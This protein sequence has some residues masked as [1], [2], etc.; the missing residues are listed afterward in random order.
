MLS[1][2]SLALGLSLLT[3]S[4]PP[5]PRAAA[6]LAA[7]SA[8]SFSLPSPIE[9]LKRLSSAEARELQRELLELAFEQDPQ[10]V[11][12]RSLDLAR[13]VRV[14]G[15]ETVQGLSSAAAAPEPPVIL[16]RM[17][18]ELGATYVKLGQFIASSPTLFPP[19][20]VQ[21][22]QKCLDATPPMPWSDVKEIVEAE[23]GRPIGQ[24]Y[25]S[26]D[27]T[28]LAAA[29]I[30]QVHAARL[31][32]GED[33]VLKVQKKGVQGSLKADL[34]LLYANARVLQLLGAAT[35]LAAQ[36]TEQFAEFLARSPE[37]DGVVTVPKVYR[38]A[39][40]SRLLTLERLYGVPLI[41]LE[42]VRKYQP[43]PE[44]AL[45]VALNTWVS[46]VLTNEWFHADVHAGNLLVLTDGRDFPAGRV[47]FIDF[48]IV[49][50][51][52]AATAEGMLDFV[53]SFPAGDMA[54]VGRALEKMGFTKELSEEQSAAF[55]KD[56]GEVIASIDSMTAD[57]ATTASAGAAASA[58]DETQLNRAVAAVA[59]VAEGYGIR[60]PR[61][62]ALLIKQVLYFDRYTSLLAPG[63]DVLNDERLSMNRP[64]GDGGVSS[65]EGGSVAVEVLPPEDDA[66]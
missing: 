34:D 52:P 35:A 28:P 1:L 27:E 24:V 15:S 45:I 26:V 36:R 50:A 53:R 58:I 19:E 48:G 57:I 55:A 46:S 42:S 62:F 4:R 49:G 2:L 16:R 51:I 61:E 43:Q 47:A 29:S 39:S 33:V 54:G 10:V 30:A 5:A 23:L 12:R 9:T 64:P 63:L 21:E 14:V 22:F 11:V 31:L 8:P 6:R 38:A 17:C 13:A 20:Y 37:L 40:A 7:S 25:A 65:V 66:E 60:F 59:R 44:L 3:T 41:D 18:E 56:I 32:S